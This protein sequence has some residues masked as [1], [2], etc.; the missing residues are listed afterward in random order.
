LFDHAVLH[1]RNRGVETLLIQSLSENTAMLRIVRAAG[2]MVE[3]DGGESL[4]RLRLPADSLGSHIEELVGDQV[5]EIDY[6]L[7]REAVRFTAS[8]QD[9]STPPAPK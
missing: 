9:K 5:A 6:R 8:A 1:A 4:A 3:R 7:K 2:A